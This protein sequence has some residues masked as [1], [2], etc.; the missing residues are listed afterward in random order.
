[1]RADTAAGRFA[2]VL[3]LGIDVSEAL[4]DRW[5]GWLMPERQPYAISADL[6]ARLGLTEQVGPLSPELRDSFELYGLD[7]ETIVWLTVGQARAL[8]AEVR[9][10]QPAAHRWPS[11]SPAE[12]V[13]RTIRYVE[14]GRRPSR[15][16]DVGDRTWRAAAGATPMA[17]R[18]AGRFP[19]ASGP[20]CFGTVMGACGVAG[21]E[22]VW[23]QRAPFEEWLADRAVPGGLD[24]EAG[25]VLVWRNADGAVQH[26]AV[27]L[28]DGWALHKPSQGW[29]SPTK[30]LS[31]PQVKA[32]SRAPG[33]YLHRYRLR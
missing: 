25:T 11:R 7:D 22:Q 31:I 3:V 20:N 16:R 18:L 23:M 14:E 33:R 4:V 24:S 32:S 30:V 6:A 28:G 10:A 15:H 9:R 21:A 26:A 17:R 29:M 12:S 2:D 8:P 19:G 27:T 13:R 5:R 1:M